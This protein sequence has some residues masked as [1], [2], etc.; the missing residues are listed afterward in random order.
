MSSILTSSCCCG[1]TGCAGTCLLTSYTVSGL[2]GSYLGRVDKDFSCECYTDLCTGAI[3]S[4]YS[5]DKWEFS[6]TATQIGTA[7]LTRY[8]PV[9]FGG[10]CY[11][12]EGTMS[13]TGSLTLEQIVSWYRCNG[14]QLPDGWAQECLNTISVPFTAEVPFCY[15]VACDSVSSSE[16]CTWG[17]TGAIWKHSL[18]ICDFPIS[19]SEE[20]LAGTCSSGSS[21]S[22]GDGFALAGESC[23][24]CLNCP[25]QPYGII[26]KGGTFNWISKIKDF[27]NITEYERGE[28]SS[29]VIQSSCPFLPPD[30]YEPSRC[31]PN[32]VNDA[33]LRGPFTIAIVDEFTDDEGPDPW[34]PC[35]YLGG[36]P[37]LEIG[38]YTSLMAWFERLGAF[39]DVPELWP[40]TPCGSIDVNFPRP[41]D[42]CQDACDSQQEFFQSISPAYPSYS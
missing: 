41:G 18:Q 29:C 13:I 28:I 14:D 31:F 40:C 24:L 26:C 27:R 9:P 2:G 25:K 7:V 30:P 6:F 39:D 12:A 4:P 32:L 20:F 36:G 15:T 42:P 1:S 10:C 38:F 34:I 5:A 22:D 17:A 11:K 8:G 35:N 16:I 3:D 21:C 33:G 19:G 37:T 23:I